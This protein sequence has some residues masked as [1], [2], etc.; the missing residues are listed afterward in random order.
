MQCENTWCI[1]QENWHCI[2]DETSIDSI[3]MCMECIC[4]SY[5]SDELE[6]KKREKR[7]QLDKDFYG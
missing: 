4:I 7:E 6:R 1:Y 5:E 3:G 2:L